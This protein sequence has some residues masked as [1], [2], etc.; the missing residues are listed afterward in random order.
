M[1]PTEELHI[2]TKYILNLQR[3]NNLFIKDK[4]TSPKESIVM[5]VPLIYRFPL[6]YEYN[7]LLMV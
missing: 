3:Q 2:L 7:Q 6:F 1:V 5:E 4:M